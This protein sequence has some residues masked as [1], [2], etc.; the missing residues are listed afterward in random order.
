MEVPAARTLAAL[1]PPIHDVDQNGNRELAEDVMDISR[2]DADEGEITDYSPESPN[3]VEDQVPLLGSEDTYEPPLTIDPVPLHTSTL[4]Q[5]ENDSHVTKSNPSHVTP[6]GTQEDTEPS[7]DSEASNDSSEDTNES[8]E[9]LDASR[10][11]PLND[12]SDPDDYEPP[13]PATPVEAPTPL[14]SHD[15]NSTDTSFSQR[16]PNALSAIQSL[17]ANVTSAGQDRVDSIATKIVD[18]DSPTVRS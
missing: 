5:G 2:S 4:Q 13:E 18:T 10:S 8:G 12:D 15:I 7:R 16:D 17:S 14:L 11:Q 1:P 3:L 9:I 6:T